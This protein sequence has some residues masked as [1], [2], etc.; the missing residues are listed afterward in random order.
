MD[1]SIILTSD[2][3]VKKL[4]TQIT[5]VKKQVSEFKEHD[6]EVLS[7]NGKTSNI[8]NM[9][10]FNTETFVNYNVS[11][12]SIIFFIVFIVFILFIKYYI[13]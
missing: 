4:L 13:I 12:R 2:D 10:L 11:R 1:N 7:F 5:Q 3:P 9:K 6:N 8:P